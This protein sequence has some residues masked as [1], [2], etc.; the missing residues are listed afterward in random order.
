MHNKALITARWVMEKDK[1]RLAIDPFVELYN[2]EAGKLKAISAF[3]IVEIQK[4]EAE[5]KFN[6]R[7]VTVDDFDNPQPSLSLVNLGDYSDSDGFP[8]QIY[9]LFEPANIASTHLSSRYEIY[10]DEIE[11]DEDDDELDLTIVRLLKALTAPVTI[12]CTPPQV[13]TYSEVPRT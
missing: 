10:V 8:Y 9:T 7:N 2:I 12:C 3:S 13:Q 5:R 6:N 4:Y 11:L 1:W